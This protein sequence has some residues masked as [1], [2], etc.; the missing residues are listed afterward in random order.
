ME[1]TDINII[2]DFG[3]GM[4]CLQNPSLISR[5]LSLSGIEKVPQVYSFWKWG[6]IV[7]VIFAAFTG[8]IN[9][10]KLLIIRVRTVKCLPSVS[11]P[12]LQESEDDF[13]LTDDET[14]SSV[15]AS[16]Y[17]DDTDQTSTF[18]D[19]RQ[20]DEDFRVAGSSSCW[21]RQ[22]QNG[23]SKLG[24]RCSVGDLFSWPEFSAGKSVVKLWDS[25]GLGLDFE[26]SFETKISTW[27]LNKDVKISSI[28]GGRGQI[29][30]VAL[31]SPAVLLSGELSNNAGFLLAAHDVR[32]GRHNPAIR[33]EWR[34]RLG[35]AAGIHSGG[36]EKVYVR[37]GITGALTVGDLRNANIP[38]ENSTGADG[39]TWWDAHAVIDE[40][41]E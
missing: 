26:D 2:T 7:L 25:F 40:F 18:E 9:R 36:N 24:R 13:D 30:A 1:I 34:P 4:K 32:M 14:S 21:G 11:Q 12:L 31:A 29:P 37:D 3:A 6:A 5:F 28:F 39:E 16:D 23:D 15:A 19:R 41:G 10:I 35:K 17:D 27:D 8:V 22:W 38:L 20:V 33:A